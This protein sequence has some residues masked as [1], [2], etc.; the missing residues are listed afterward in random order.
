M[1]PLNYHVDVHYLMPREMFADPKQAQTLKL[2]GIE[3]EAVGNTVLLF[4][5]PATL[6]AAQAAPE[7][8]RTAMLDAGFGL[9]LSGQTG[10]IEQFD[11][12]EDRHRMKKF[13]KLLDAV[14]AHPM[15]WSRFEGGFDTRLLWAHESRMQ[16]LAGMKQGDGENITGVCLDLAQALEKKAGLPSPTWPTVEDARRG[17]QA[18][19]ERIVRA[20]GP[21][22]RVSRNRRRSAR[23]ALPMRLVLAV[24]LLGLPIYG[25]Y[26]TDVGPLAALFGGEIIAAGR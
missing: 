19:A 2:A 13:T 11:K 16:A 26:L 25:P 20:T 10:P 4:R 17:Q 6:E 5:D 3:A 12:L 8:L 1:K 9:N 15:G 14:K 24:A 22:P 18:D 23:T 7:W 21:K